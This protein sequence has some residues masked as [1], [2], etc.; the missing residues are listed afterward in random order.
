MGVTALLP[1]AATLGKGA[2]KERKMSRAS[3]LNDPGHWRDR[4]TEMRALAET[5]QEA[6]TRAIMQRLA[7]DYEKLADRAALR[8]DGGGAR[9]GI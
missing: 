5:M 4:A 6:E 3:Q 9:T 2:S 8:S 7:D 1:F